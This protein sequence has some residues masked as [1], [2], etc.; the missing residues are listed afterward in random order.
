MPALSNSVALI[1]LA[2]KYAHG[3]RDGD[4]IS[5]A[6]SK[7]AKYKYPDPKNWAAGVHFIVIQAAIPS[8]TLVE[9]SEG[10]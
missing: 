10:E 1:V 6:P 4:L 8:R 3:S 2:R 5:P 9:M 7:K